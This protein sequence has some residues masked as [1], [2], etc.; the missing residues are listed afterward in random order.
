MRKWEALTYKWV[1]GLMAF[2]E[3]IFLTHT[4]YTKSQY[5]TLLATKFYKGF[6]LL[7]FSV[8]SHS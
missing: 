6:D 3:R 4:G 5:Y 1:S 8:R 2:P 7:L